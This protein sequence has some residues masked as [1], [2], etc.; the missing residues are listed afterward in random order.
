MKFINF[1]VIVMTLLIF[2][3]S[4][5]IYSFA[6]IEE[7][8]N[9]R[10]IGVEEGL[11]Q[12]TVETIFQDSKGYIW[13]GTNDGLDRYNGYK[14]KHYK[15]DIYDEN[16]ISNNYIVDIVEDSDGYIWVTTINGLNRIDVNTNSIKRYYSDPKK[17]NLSNDNLWEIIFTS[18]NQL[19]VTSVN[20]VS[21]YD[22][23]TDSFKRIL[24]NGELPSQFIYSIHED[25]NQNIWVGTD[26]GLVKF[27]KNLTK[28]FDYSEK[29]KSSEVYRIRHDDSNNIWVCTLGNGLF[30]ISKDDN[31][32]QYVSSSGQYSLPDNSVRDILIDAKNK[33]WVCTGNGISEFDSNKNT[34][35]TYKSLPYDKNSLINNKTFC[36]LE[37]SSGLIWI[38]TY[39][40]I[41][42]FNP[43]S[44]F[45]YFTSSPA[46][47]NGV[48]G[49]MIHGIYEDNNLT[50]VGTNG[51]GISVVNKNG[52]EMYSLTTKNSN[53]IDDNIQEITG[54][55]NRVY[56]GTNSGLNVVEA[57]PNPSQSVIVES[58]CVEDGLPSNRIR[59]LYV[60]KDKYL[61]I[62]T[63]NGLAI[64]NPKTK[65][66]MDLTYILDKAGVS[67][68]FIR[69]IFQDSAGE[70]YIGCF[71]GGGLIRINP[72]TNS[73]KVYRSNRNDIYSI[74]DNTVRDINED[75]LGN[76][77]IA[78]SHG[79]NILNKNSN[80]FK[81][82]TERDGLPN[83]TIYGI[84]VDKLNNIWMSTNYGISKLNLDK[85][86]F[87]NFTMIDGLQDNEFNGNSSFENSN[88]MF[89]FGGV[90]GFNMFNPLEVK[91]YTYAPSVVFDTCEISGIESPIP[92]DQRLSYKEN[93]IKISYF[94]S[95]YKNSSSTKY[96]YK[97]DG[98]SSEWKTTDSN[99]ILFAGLS[100]GEYTLKIKAMNHS[101]VVGQAE[102][103]NFTIKPPFWKSHI[104]SF[105]YFLIVNIMIYLNVNKVKKLDRLVNNRTKELKSEMEKNNKLYEKVLTLE[106]NKNNYFVNLSHELRTPLNV[107]NSISQLLND[108][109]KK[110]DYIKADRMLHYA[111]MIN[112][113]CN[114][115]L[116]L[117]NNLIDNTKLQSDNYTLTKSN[118]NIVYVVE[119]TVI[120]MKDFI[121]SKGIN[122]T[123]DTDTEEKIISCDK[124]E[125]ERCIINLVGNAV[126]FT[127]SGGSI[128]VFVHGLEDEVRIT[129]K[130]NG[131]GISKE[132]QK[133][134]FDKFNQVVD[135]HSEVK[136]GS[137][138]GLTIV[139]QL[140]ELHGGTIYVESELGKGSMFT[141][142]LPAD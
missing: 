63:N 39:G 111:D 101:G 124:I 123:F 122:F 14:F 40:G 21:I 18:N 93:N 76:I 37:D 2:I 133:N 85:E 104:A 100:P 43:N 108:I 119:E 28:I 141:I 120:S 61:W 95:D 97:M 54:D 130:D 75:N 106:K 55:D 4:F 20:G 113:N 70:Y 71:L 92:F 90:N 9:F 132:N 17:G 24:N 96:Y 47:G 137:G 118:E 64:L 125:I 121:E 126:K 27:D 23:K 94:T 89:F 138:L 114:R 68:T 60:D 31:V 88:G 58:Y 32:T 140:V 98:L 65:Q 66:I 131:I 73:V 142:I 110:D 56:I 51:N 15:Y 136:G 45:S 53:L 80:T 129:V 50:W 48:N 34:F 11:S 16:T 41:S 5:S 74:S 22:K 62:G 49:Y 72:K 69:S 107:L 77:L 10:N 38:G 82:F 86:T 103:I 8:Y 78:T 83:N 91:T 12:N 3:N 117:I 42:R 112:R 1:K 52:Y 46:N 35:H 13:I 115:L 59:S 44:N 134:I 84:L 19:I 26:K 67:D 87:E 105:I 116:N 135:S 139:K 7:R 81:H 99:E 127:N 79:L 29:I 30:R 102:S 128:D 6:S 109:G 25:K 57:S 36:I 33:I